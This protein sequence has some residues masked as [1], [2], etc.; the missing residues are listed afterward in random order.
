M[1][2]VWAG[3]ILFVLLMLALDLGVY[4]HRVLFWGILGALVMRGVMIAVGAELIARYHWI[5]YV[6][7]VFL[8]VTAVKMLLGASGPAAA[9]TSR[10]DT[11]HL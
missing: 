1:M 10:R 7:R 11:D 6:F 2:W 5:L 9:S 4:Q 3:F 8:L